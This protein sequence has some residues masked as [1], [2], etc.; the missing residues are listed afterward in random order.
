MK[1]MIF[2]LLAIISMF[3]S[4]RYDTEDVTKTIPTPTTNDE[5]NT[6]TETKTEE[7]EDDITSTEPTDDTF[8][9]YKIYVKYYLNNEFV[10]L[11]TINVESENEEYY[12]T[13]GMTFN[14]TSSEFNDF[15]YWYYLDENGKEVK[16]SF[17]D[18]VTKSLNLYAKEK[19]KKFTLMFG[20]YSNVQYASYTLSEIREH[21]TN[22]IHDYDFNMTKYGDDDEYDYS[23]IICTD[24]DIGVT[25]HSDI[26]ST[27]AFYES[28][29]S[30]HDMTDR[31]LK[32]ITF[33][34]RKTY[35]IQYDLDGG[36]FVNESYGKYE[37]NCANLNLYYELPTEPFVYK[38][39]ENDV[40]E[41]TFEGWYDE[42]ENLVTAI[43]YETRRNNKFHAK[44]SSKKIYLYVNY[45]DKDTLVKTS[46]FRI[47]D[48][49]KAENIDYSYD[50]ETKEFLGW[51]DSDGNDFDFNTVLMEDLNLYT[52]SNTFSIFEFYGER[53]RTDT[54]VSS[55]YLTSQ[56]N[57]SVVA[58][59]NFPIFRIENTNGDWYAN[60]YEYLT[61]DYDNGDE[62]GSSFSTV[63]VWERLVKK[64]V[65]L[66]KT[67]LISARAIRITNYDMITNVNVL[68]DYVLYGKQLGKCVEYTLHS[69]L[70]SSD[71]VPDQ[72]AYLSVDKIKD[73]TCHVF[74]INLT[75][76]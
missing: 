64:N 41:Y 9:P 35:T 52:K 2:I 40:Y 65:S 8:K 67:W 73:I 30:N 48:N 6:S 56:S 20:Q 70:Y 59:N 11:E 72:N 76:M 50:I 15:D 24:Q 16:F 19:E 37:Y 13:Y 26:D 31:Q 38:I 58:E 25:Y 29:I 4:C 55:E 42:N 51:T 39:D 18:K 47:K 22:H 66:S 33:A 1:K 57:F 71:T 69:S 14:P 21:I 62:V 34:T 32:F 53:Y 45:Y 27:I 7:T 44:W 60:K 17:D 75:K 68:D 43:T 10:Y 46:K 74:G 49:P 3:V 63:D 5:E 54:Y 12:S 36:K 28:Y 23:Y 61:I